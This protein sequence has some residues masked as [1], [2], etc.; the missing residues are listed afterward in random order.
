MSD[1]IPGDRNTIFGD[2]YSG[3]INPNVVLYRNYPTRYHG[4]NFVVPGSGTLPYLSSPLEAPAKIGL[5]DDSGALAPLGYASG[6]RVLDA[7]AC[8]A[9]GYFAAPKGEDKILWAA[10]SAGAGFIS[11]VLGFVGVGAAAIIKRRK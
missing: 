9:I 6:N 4:P 11:G 10:L 1:L 2:T 5:G 8:S 7:L 3:V